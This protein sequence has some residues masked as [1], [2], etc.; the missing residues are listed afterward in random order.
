MNAWINLTDEETDGAWNRVRLKLRFRPSVR[1]EDWPG[2][3]EPRPYRTFSVNRFWDAPEREGLAAD[4]E[5]KAARML[6]TCMAPTDR[7]YAL[8]WQHSCYWLTPHLLV[9]GVPWT[10]PAYP[11]GDYYMFFS[12]DLDIGWFGH[13]WEQSICVFGSR[14][15]RALDAN[16]PALFTE[17]M[18]AAV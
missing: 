4:L 15:L 12:E 16:K 2:I 11:D 5:S 13:P 6:Q 9:A 10:V 17:V 14:L 8:D 3:L 1:A 18:R 7:L